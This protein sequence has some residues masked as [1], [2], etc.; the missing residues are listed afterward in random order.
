MYPLT[1]M[2]YNIHSGK[3]RRMLPTLNSMIRFMENSHA[4]VMAIQ[5]INENEKR[6]YQVSEI[7]NSLRIN[8]SFASNVSIGKG[9]YGI[10]TFTPFFILAQHHI[11]LPSEKEQRGLLHT[12]LSL[13]NQKLHILNTHLGLSKAE[14][15]H[16][17]HTIREYI[18]RLK[19]P[20]ILLGDFNTTNPELQDTGLTDAAQITGQEH[21]PTFIPNR[22]RI[23]Y[24]F[25]SPSIKVL[26]YQVEPVTL[27]DH[28]PVFIQVL[29]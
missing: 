1:L 17:F 21:M 27:S 7:K 20:V 2:T 23:D 5:E 26:A 29:I 28:Y 14:R 4:D 3:D 15:R 19:S 24:I 25:L 10:A 6:G 11:L 13:G 16:Q 8:Y 9:C 22:R 18:S 12:V